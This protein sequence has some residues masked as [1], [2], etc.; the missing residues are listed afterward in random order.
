MYISKTKVEGA[1]KAQTI[2]E[3]V[4]QVS[5][6][7]DNDVEKAAGLENGDVLNSQLSA[8]SIHS[9]DTSYIYGRL[10]LLPAVSCWAANSADSQP[11]FQ[12]DMLVNKEFSSVAIQGRHNVN[13]WVTKY[14]VQTSLDGSVWKDVDGGALFVGSS[15]RN[16]VV[17]NDFAQNEI[18]RY[19]RI[20]CIEK[21]NWFSARF[22]VYIME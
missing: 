13:Q 15:D 20:I 11:W 6:A 9:S 8:S 18:G 16:T 14:R 22:E 1:L 2:K 3:N 17:K 10:N 19:I 7:P 4:I 5:R 12:V 21:N